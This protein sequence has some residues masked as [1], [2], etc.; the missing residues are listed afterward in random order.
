LVEVLVNEQAQELDENNQFSITVTGDTTVSV[1]YNFD[2]VHAGTAED[3][4]DVADAI[5]VAQAV[6]T[7]ATSNE[8]YVSGVISSVETTT[9]NGYAT[10]FIGSEGQ[11]FEIY[12]AK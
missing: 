3:P 12:K 4:F 5:T 9:N 10:F 1:T 2:T 7:I 11:A 8:Y 6:G